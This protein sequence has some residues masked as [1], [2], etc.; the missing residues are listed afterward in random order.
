MRHGLLYLFILSLACLSPVPGP[1]PLAAAPADYLLDKERSSVSFTYRFGDAPSRGSMP[2]EAARIRLDPRNI[3]NSSVSVTL[4]ADRAEAGFFLTNRIIRGSGVLDA[5]AHPLIRFESTRI[6]GTL[7][8]AV[9]E[10]NVTIRGVTRP[11]TLNARLFRPEGSDPGD[12]SRLSIRLTGA[13][14]RRDFGADGYSALVGDEIGL[15][16]V[17]RLER[18]E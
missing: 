14:N 12:L 5:R 11:M 8:D 1:A 3:A 13:F 16:I 2:V 18:S 17:V 7:S 10:G 9:V 15:R 4:R 6:L